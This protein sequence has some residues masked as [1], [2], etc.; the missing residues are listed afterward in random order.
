MLTVTVIR[1]FVELDK[2]STSWTSVITAPPGTTWTCRAS[3]ITTWILP[4]STSKSKSTST[5]TSTSKADGCPCGNENAE[6]D[7]QLSTIPLPSASVTATASATVPGEDVLSPESP[8]PTTFAT[9]KE[10]RF[11][12]AQNVAM[13]DDFTEMFSNLNRG[14]TFKGRKVVSKD[15]YLEFFGLSDLHSMTPEGEGVL[16]KFAWHDRDGDGYLDADEMM[17]RCD[18]YGCDD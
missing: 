2:P 6:R 5:S 16:R 4:S 7:I 15:Q 17:L 1:E 12:S 8:V 3:H 13:D 10:P 9:V 11:V 14:F 18:E